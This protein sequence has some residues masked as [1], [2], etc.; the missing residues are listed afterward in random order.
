MIRYF[1]AHPTAANLLMVGLIA[2]GVAAI[3]EVKRETFP[4]I[5]A[6]EVEVRLPFP[7][8]SAEDVEEA[9]CQRIED[10]ADT[11]A[12]IR[13]KRCEAREGVAIAVLQM[14][15]GASIDRFLDDVKTEI[16]AIDTFP[17]DA[18]IPVIR[19]LER[20]DFVASI[21]VTGRLSPVDLKA[22]GEQM[23]DRVLLIDG[24][25]QVTVEGFSDHQIR[26]EIPATVLRQ[27]GLSMDGLA[28]MV[29]GQSVDLPSG[30]IE[31]SDGTVLIRFADERR[32]PREFEDL[33]VVTSSSGAEIR[34]G[35]IATI[36]D[37]FELDEEKSLFNGRRAAF[38][39]VEKGKEDDTLSVVDAL[40]A[41]LEKERKIAPPSMAFALTQDV[42]SIV[43]DRLSMLLR[44][45]AQGLV[46]VFLTLWLFFSFRFSFWVVMGLP[47]SFLGTVAVMALAGYSFDMI[48]MVGLLIAVGLL[49]DDAIVLS[50]NIAAHMKQGKS[51]LAAAV[52]G[53]RQV[54]PGVIASFLTT[55]CV[56]AAL[57]F[58][59]GEIGAI[60]KV[61][62]VILIVTLTVSLVEAFLILPHHLAHALGGSE[63]RKPSAFRRRIDGTVEWIRDDVVGRIIDTAV[64]WRYLT[65][66]LVVAV[67]LVSL[68]M[69]AGGV[70]K[71]QA[72]PDLEGD[73]MEAR[74][75]L[76]QG[77]PLRRTEDVVGRV[78]A[79][80]SR[81]DAEF[82]RRQPD[83]PPL[84]RNVGV[85]YNKNVD[86][87]ESG[88]HVATVLVDLV[89]SEV[90][91]I[92]LD[93][94]IGRWRELAGDIPDV[95]DIKYTQPQFGPGGR[96]VDIRL[97]GNDLG[98]LK[99]ASLALQGWL[100]AYTGVLDLSDDLRPGKPEIRVRL[101]KGATMLGFSAA[102]IA[103][104][105]HTAFQGKTAREIQVGAE[106]FEVDIRV[107]PADR[108]SL[109]DL[110]Y[111][112]VTAPDGEQVP[113]HA[114]AVLEPGRGFARINRVNGL[115][116]ITIRGDINTAITNASEIVEDTR[117]RFLPELAERYPG[118]RVSF[119]GQARESAA[120]GS[121]LR[122]NFLI[123]ALG[124]FL[125]LSFQFRS[126]IE[127]VVVM[128]AI[129]LGL[130]GVVWG[131]LLM[132]L[133]LSMPSVVGYVSLA[134][135]VVNDS[136]LLVEFIRIR[137]RA[138][139]TVADAARLA[140]RQRFR[141]ILLTS[142][143]TMAGLLPLL[144][145]TS[146]Q[147]QV[148]LP[149]VTSLVFGLFSATLLVL[150]MVPTL[151]VILD[152]YGL[153]RAVEEGETRPA[154]APRSAAA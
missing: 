56:F 25:S 31:A 76:P 33:V 109:A 82:A 8:A 143:T 93:Q 72:F 19:Q 147:A 21:A 36:T 68:S 47:V 5:P 69:V 144:T 65:A 126:Y 124:V 26:I 77:T 92:P 127:P 45:G 4:D 132:G 88:P 133:E 152:D 120:T 101:N 112:T 149:L 83:R 81:V 73:V 10:V 122:R 89:G 34:L 42:A 61:L 29:A 105:L 23:K 135:V 44:N 80:L 28:D 137:R 142:L 116:T 114:V 150:V 17:A 51:A 118:V 95:I 78:T 91:D 85:Q 11:I 58:M 75:L 128:A 63:G 66:G 86:A 113:L 108:D 110:D 43:R 141:A 59:K 119:E 98:E 79:A 99:A 16:D 62:P 104:Q 27:Y 32:R 3:P 121:S 52:E 2:A 136:I 107:A 39:R 55:I 22:Y 53:S 151:Y 50:E 87:F 153:T 54:A 96:P 7:G 41:F 146:L 129:P 46:L 70:L 67:L 20:T 18:E 37:R 35:D 15:E 106:A 64:R 60:L 57:A 145:E 14:R 74:I 48:T 9:I 138:G 90:R 24:V 1:A 103:A 131:H 30:S 123:G 154:P 130:I 97:M 102:D 139:E 134:G 140:A 71:F 94:I 115:R 40:K 13:E 49:M 125:L 84:V 38:L 6:D 117:K 111:F 100:K 12:D 148:L